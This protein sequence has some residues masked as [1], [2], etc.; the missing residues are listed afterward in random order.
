MSSGQ[1]QYCVC[2]RSS[3][4]FDRSVSREDKKF[5]MTSHK[6]YLL[7]SASAEWVLETGQNVWKDVALYSDDPAFCFEKNLLTFGVLVWE[8]NTHEN[9][10]S[11]HYSLL[12][13]PSA[14]HNS[15]GRLGIPPE[16]TMFPWGKVSQ[17]TLDYWAIKVAVLIFEPLFLIHTSLSF[18][19]KGFLR[20]LSAWVLLKA[21]CII[22][23]YF[24]RLWKSATKL[25]LWQQRQ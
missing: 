14:Y 16:L 21:F 22:E 25:W 13:I 10:G 8:R 11:M 5:Y 15:K 4:A 23:L 9:V 17:S 1:P 7:S 24:I 12:V 18:S 2:S 6:V 19:W 3:D 20:F